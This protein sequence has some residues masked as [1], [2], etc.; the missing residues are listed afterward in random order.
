MDLNLAATNILNYTS[1]QVVKA[2]ESIHSASERE[3]LN[4]AH[5]YV[6]QHVQPIYTVDE[7][8]PVSVTLEKGRGACSQRIACVEAFARAAGIPTR[9]QVLWVTG[10]FWYPRFALW[11]HPF[12]PQRIMLLWAQFYVDN[13]WLDF[14][15]VVAPLHQLATQ[16]EHGFTNADETLFDAVA[17]RPVDFSNRMQKCE[18]NNDYDLSGYVVGDGGI[19]DSR[20]DALKAYGSF[21]HTLRGLAFERLFGNQASWQPA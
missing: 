14:S 1:P 15:E 5:R 18:C 7:F 12:I 19:F 11:T 4:A 16:S 9:V 21:Q 13:T 6:S 20:D 10:K 8:Q 2:V 3:F 17:I